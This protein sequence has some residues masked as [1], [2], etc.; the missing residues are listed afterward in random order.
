MGI[1]ADA[2]AAIQSDAAGYLG[3]QLAGA[4][5]GGLPGF[6]G[7][8]GGP[9]TYPLGAFPVE[10]YISQNPWTVGVRNSS[11]IAYMIGGECRD[12]LRRQRHL[13]RFPAE[14]RCRGDDRRALAGSGPSATEPTDRRRRSVARSD[15]ADP[16]AELFDAAGGAQRR[17]T[18]PAVFIGGFGDFR[19]S[20]GTDLQ[21]STTRLVLHLDVEVDITAVSAGQ[22]QRHRAGFWPHYAIAAGHQFC[23][24][25]ACRTGAQLTWRFAAHSVGRRHGC[26]SDQASVGDDGTHRWCGRGHCGRFVRQPDARLAQRHD[27]PDDSL[28]GYRLDRA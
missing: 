18:A 19:I 1:S 16:S 9:W 11:N 23:R 17:F 25:I 24:W 14:A 12:D 5:N 27:Q 13:A 21:S 22:Q 7:P 15:L 4:L 6:F 20:A 28:A 26:E 10:V 3:S 2:F 8:A